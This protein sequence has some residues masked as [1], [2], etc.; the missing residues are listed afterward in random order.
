MTKLTTFLITLSFCFAAC[1]ESDNNPQTQSAAEN[2]SPASASQE[3]SCLADFQ[4]EPW[5]LFS[6]DEVADFVG[7]AAASGKMEE[8]MLTKNLAFRAAGYTWETGRTMTTKV[9]GDMKIPVSD[10]VTIGRFEVLDPESINGTFV[11]HFRN[12]YQVPREQQQAELDAAV[13]KQLENESEAA[14]SFGKGISNISKSINYQ[15]IAGIGSAAVWQTNLKS[16]DGML[17]ILHNNVTF[18]VVTNL[19]D[20]RDYNLEVAKKIALAV[21]DK[22]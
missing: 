8:P 10:T 18:T 11:E 2:S 5:T 6:L 14:Q 21:I 1:S 16:P 3:G 15:T 20:N 12:Q 17:N 19:S 7:L 13:T 4:A 22:C 9:T